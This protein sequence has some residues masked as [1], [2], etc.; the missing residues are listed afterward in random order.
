M[1]APSRIFFDDV[2]LE[3]DRLQ[4]DLG[5]RL[6]CGVSIVLGAAGRKLMRRGARGGG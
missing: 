4:E 1:E 5:A 2:V 6:G 3:R